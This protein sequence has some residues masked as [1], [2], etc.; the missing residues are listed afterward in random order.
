VQLTRGL[1]Q[2]CLE[3]KVCRRG[4]EGETQ[5]RQVTGISGSTGKSTDQKEVR[6]ERLQAGIDDMKMLGPR[7]RRPTTK[8]SLSHLKQLERFYQSE[9][10]RGV[11]NEGG[12]QHF[13]AY[14]GEA[15]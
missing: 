9:K 13:S 5:P 8:A 4:R 6:G 12:T 2:R 7:G 1:T 3:R 10:E 15:K 14:Q 11:P